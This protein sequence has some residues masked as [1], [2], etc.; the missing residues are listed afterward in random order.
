MQFSRCVDVAWQL[1][2]GFKPP[3]EL[4]KVTSG[5]CG[6]DLNRLAEI[7]QGRVK[8]LRAAFPD[9][10]KPYDAVWHNKL[11]FYEVPN[12]DYFAIDL[13]TADRAPV[14]YLSH[15]DGSGHGYELGVDFVDFIER[16]SRLGNPGPEDWKWLPFATSPQALLDP[17]GQAGKVWR[18]WFGLA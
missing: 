13:A 9:R 8:M 5:G 4:R 1:P 15:D 14:V 3:G 2:A 7:D 16:H 6:W 12:G 11:A 10:S 18:G 17:D